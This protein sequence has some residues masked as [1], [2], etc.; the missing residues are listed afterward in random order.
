MYRPEYTSCCMRRCMDSVRT[1]LIGLAGLLAVGLATGQTAP[2]A[3]SASAAAPAAPVC[4]PAAREV[5]AESLAPLLRARVDYGP[6]WKIEKDGRASWLYGTIHLARFEWL[7]P[8]EQVMKALREADTLA[9]ELNL[10]DPDVLKSLTQ[11]AATK[12]GDAG[13][14]APRLERLARLTAAACLP[15]NALDGL[16]PAMRAITLVM[17]GSRSEGLYPQFGIDF[18]LA[19]AAQALKKPIVALETAELQ[20]SLLIGNTPD[21]WRKSLDSTLDALESGLARAP[22]T[23]TADAWARADMAR[24]EDF[25]TWCRCMDTPHDRATMKRTLDDRNG[26]MA[27]KIDRLHGAG[28]RVF[29]GVGVLHMVGEQGLP[30]LMQARGFRV[31]PIG[32]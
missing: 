11:P 4:P 18:V 17:L 3:P 2:I 32:R 10:L 28:Q 9:L 6:L 31:S 13:L 16:H 7:V 29:A 21:E 20:K 30:A 14:D 1:T 22:M 19:G 24:F 8:G 15:P 5:T 23:A 12:P 27:D 26:P 25:A